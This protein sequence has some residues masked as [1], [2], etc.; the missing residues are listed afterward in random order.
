M[1]LDLGRLPGQIERLAGA[2]QIPRRSEAA[3]ERSRRLEQDKWPAE[4]RCDDEGPDQVEAFSAADSYGGIDPR[5]V[6]QFQA[7]AGDIGVRIANP[8]HHPLDSGIDDSWSAGRS[9]ALVVAGLEGDIE[10]RSARGIARVV[11]GDRLGV[12][13]PGAEMA[14]A[15]DDLAVKHDDRA[16]RRVGPGARRQIGGQAQGL[17]HECGIHVKHGPR[18]GTG[19]GSD[20]RQVGPQPART[21]RSRCSPTSPIQTLTVGPGIPPGRPFAAANG[22][23]AMTVGGDFHPAPKLWARLIMY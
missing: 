2:V 7:A 13:M 10:R 8:D 9:P 16:D 3:V 1:H 18:T 19:V 11:Q 22:S 6:D 15:T 4:G 5:R 12:I 17:G 21:R 14:A 23:R 20:G